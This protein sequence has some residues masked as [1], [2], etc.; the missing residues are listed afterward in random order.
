MEYIWYG[1]VDANMSTVNTL[2]I[3]PDPTGPYDIANKK[4]VDEHG[5]GGG[6]GVGRIRSLV[7]VPLISSRLATFIE[8]LPATS[9]MAVFYLTLH[10]N[11]S[12]AAQPQLNFTQPPSTI[13][14]MDWWGGNR[15]TEYVDAQSAN[16]QQWLNITSVQLLA[17]T[18]PQQIMIVMS[19]SGNNWP[20]ASLSTSGAF[21]LENVNRTI[22]LKT[23]DPINGIEIRNGIVSGSY[24]KGW[25]IDDVSSEAAPSTA[26]PSMKRLQALEKRLREIEDFNGGLY[27]SMVHAAPDELKAKI[28]GKYTPK[29]VKNFRKRAAKQAPKKPA[30]ADDKP[31]SS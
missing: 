30:L 14:P 2:G 12:S 8:P 18:P 11:P 7:D 6:G 10:F 31:P 9:W 16:N 21:T 3:V 20:I 24:V 17:S 13:I 22:T 4:Y 1:E 29:F 23:N 27:E 28:A 19:R 25:V 5:G 26:A 15:G